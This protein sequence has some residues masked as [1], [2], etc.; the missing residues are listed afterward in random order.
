MGVRC[1]IGFWLGVM[2]LVSAL[3]ASYERGQKV[4]VEWHGT[5]Y[6]AVVIEV[7]Q[8][9]W[10]IHYDGYG[11]DWDEWVGTDR[12]KPAGSKPARQVT[13]TPKAASTGKSGSEGGGEITIRQGGSIWASVSAN[14]TIRVQGSIVGEIGND[15]TVRKSGSIVG[16]VESNGTIRK[17][18]MIVGEIESGGTLRRSGMI[19]G[20]IEGD[21]TLRKDGSIWGSAAS[22]CGS[23][24]ARRKVAA[25]LAFFSDAFGF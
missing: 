2:C 25:V 6:P 24:A 19:I 15:G 14:G 8:G 18:G 16:A 4:E 1:A 20:A 7:G 3:G 9:Q 10:K 22:C 17:S 12:I 11:D 5:W 13:E 21:G 23:H